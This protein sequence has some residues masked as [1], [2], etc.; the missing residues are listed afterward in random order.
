[1]NGEIVQLPQPETDGEVALERAIARRRSRRSFAGEGL[2]LEQAG[3]VLWSAQGITDG[4]FRAAPSAGA[5]YPLELFVVV[6]EDSVEGLQTGIYNYRPQDHSLEQVLEG[7]VRG[8]L[9][10]AALNQQFVAQAPMSIVIAADYARTTGRYGERGVRY[11]HM[12]V[13]HAGGNIYLQCEALGLATVAV[14]AFD[15]QEVEEITGISGRFDA[16]YIMPVGYE[17]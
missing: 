15:D 11:V 9:A 3:Q 4:N 6:G 5:T 7:D 17:R 1:M 13:G 16:L 10:R 12:E 14:G 8:R 2:S